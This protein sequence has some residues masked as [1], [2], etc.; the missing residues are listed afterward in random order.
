MNN[1]THELLNTLVNQSDITNELLNLSNSLINNITYIQLEQINTLIFILY[2]IISLCVFLMFYVFLQI[3][4][5]VAS[6]A[7]R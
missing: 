3:L 1:T 6:A 5:L 2:I 7:W 4:N